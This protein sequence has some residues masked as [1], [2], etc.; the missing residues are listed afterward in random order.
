[1]LSSQEFKVQSSQF[2]EER[3]ECLDMAKNSAPQT[4]K[5]VRRTM[6]VNRPLYF[7][8][9]EAG[10]CTKMSSHKDPVGN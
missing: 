2:F 5:E 10:D 1:M 7:R 9:R 4:L 3:E 6:L 8:P